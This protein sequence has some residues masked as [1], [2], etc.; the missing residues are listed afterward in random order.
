MADVALD[1]SCQPNA[2]VSDDPDP[3]E[4]DFE[5]S[6]FLSNYFTVALTECHLVF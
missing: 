3:D 4:P 2:S 6:L 5:I 1:L